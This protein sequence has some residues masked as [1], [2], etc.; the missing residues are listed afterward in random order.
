MAKWLNGF[1]RHKTIQ[2]SNLQPKIPLPAR[3]FHQPRFLDNDVVRERLAH[4]VN[5]EG[6]DADTGEGFHFHARFAGQAGGAFY[7]DFIVFI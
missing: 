2:P 4:I 6:C 3:L 1:T 7:L 5:G